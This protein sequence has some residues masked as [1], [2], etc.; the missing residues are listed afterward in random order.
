MHFGE[1][2]HRAARAP[3]ETNKVAAALREQGLDTVVQAII[4]DNLRPRR[5]REKTLGHRLSYYIAPR[6]QPQT[7]AGQ[8]S[9]HIRD[10]TVIR[11]HDE[12]DEFRF[13]PH[14]AGDKAAAQ[15]AFR[16]LG[17]PYMPQC[18]NRGAYSPAGALLAWPPL[19][20]ANQWARAAMMM[21]L[22]WS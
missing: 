18:R 6:R 8:A 2:H 7:P 11:C 15:R 17:F 19:S 14:I 9:R 21:A 16:F 13:R 12:T 1:A 4:D 20:S 22:A 3:R 10:D 5:P